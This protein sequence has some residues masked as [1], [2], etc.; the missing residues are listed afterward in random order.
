MLT[1]NGR[2]WLL[3][4]VAFNEVASL[5]CITTNRDLNEHRETTNVT[6]PVMLLNN[7]NFN[8]TGLFIRVGLGT[9]TPDISDVDLADVMIS[10]TNGNGKVDV[11]TILRCI[12]AY[13]S[14]PGDGSVYYTTI[15]H[16]YSEQT[17]HI[18][19]VGLFYFLGSANPRYEGEFLLARDLVEPSILVGPYESAVCS[20][21]Y[22]F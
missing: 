18:H 4:A 10:S 14:T 9:A 22:T 5:R 2:N 6:F 20:I 12:A 21:K 8:V 11:N 17:I 16:N 15:V 1:A 13:L 7:D 19:E 3:E